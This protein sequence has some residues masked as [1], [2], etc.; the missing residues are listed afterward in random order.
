MAKKNKMKIAKKVICILLAVFMV[1][2]V[3]ATLIA[4]LIK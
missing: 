2:G 1:M 4:F 3:A